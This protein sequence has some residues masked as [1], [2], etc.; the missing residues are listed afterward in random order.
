MRTY[1]HTWMRRR[2]KLSSFDP[3]WGVSGCLVAVYSDLGVTKDGSNRVSLWGDQVDSYDGSQATDAQK[4]VWNIATGPNGYPGI[5]WDGVDD[6]LNLIMS[7]P[8]NNWTFWFVIK[9]IDNTQSQYMLDFESGRFILSPASGGIEVAYY[10]GGFHGT[11][12]PIFNTWQLLIYRVKAPNLGEIHRN[13]SAIET[14]L[15]YTQTT[16]GGTIRLGQRYTGESNP[17]EMYLAA[18]G[19]YAGAISDADL[20]TLK[21]GLNARYALW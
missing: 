8:A 15:D 12:P 16:L 20:A 4:P 5:Y 18:W 1:P 11:Q 3:T 14:G 19:A 9:S 6:A 10:D 21:A 17:T 2:G 7:L 13:A